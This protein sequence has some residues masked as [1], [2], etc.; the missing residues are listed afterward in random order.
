MTQQELQ[1]LLDL[2][3]APGTWCQGA[4]ARDID[5]E[6]CAYDSPAAVRWSIIG[7]L[8]KLFGKD[9]ALKLCEIIA[10]NLGTRS[11]SVSLWQRRFD[12]GRS[13][14]MAGRWRW[15]AY[16]QL[17]DWEDVLPPH[18]KYRVVELLKK[19]ERRSRTDGE[20]AA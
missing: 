9:R 7:A 2:Y 5:G 15:L 18:G 10:A 16:R 14:D 6:P 12:R 1:K 19:V 17:I 3:S 8:W 20:E 4:E 11:G 13:K